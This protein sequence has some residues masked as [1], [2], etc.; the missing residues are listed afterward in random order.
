MLKEF[1]TKYPDGTWRKRA[2][3]GKRAFKKKK[4]NQCVFDALAASQG[5][6]CAYCEIRIGRPDGPDVDGEVEHFVPQSTPPPPNYAL[7]FN[8]MV[9]C[10]KGGTPHNARRR[11]PVEEHKHCGALKAETHPKG[12]IL[13]PRLLPPL[14]SVWTFSEAG[15]MSPDIKAC[16]EIGVEAEL[17]ATTISQLGLD[18]PLLREARAVVRQALDDGIDPEWG[19]AEIV[20][21]VK[22]VAESDLVPASS[23]HLSPFWSTVLHWCGRAGEAVVVE[24]WGNPGDAA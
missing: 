7:E 13:D 5:F 9:A 4:G 14:P 6:I 21:Y 22:T 15:V 20:D 3:G 12:Q 11:E 2:S 16:A 17:A 18:R 19:E 24:Y 23:G 1:R 8:N 10:C